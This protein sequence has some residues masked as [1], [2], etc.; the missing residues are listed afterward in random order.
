[1]WWEGEFYSL[2]SIVWWTSMIMSKSWYEQRPVLG[3]GATCKWSKIWGRY[4]WDCVETWNEGKVGRKGE[5]L[6]A[7]K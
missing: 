1:M 3:V 2:E 7:Y 5:D 6:R 4:M